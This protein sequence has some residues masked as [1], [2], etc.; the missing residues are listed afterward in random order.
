LLYLVLAALT[1]EL[2]EAAIRAKSPK[3]VFDS[4][5]VTVGNPTADETTLVSLGKPCFLAS[6]SSYRRP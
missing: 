1:M 3:I 5:R 4:N 2:A 6:A